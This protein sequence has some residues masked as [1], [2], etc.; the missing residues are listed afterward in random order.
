MSLRQ[1]PIQLSFQHVKRNGRKFRARNDGV[2]LLSP[3]LRRQR[4][5]G[6]SLNSRS[7]WSTEKVP[8]QSRSGGEGN[9]Q[10]KMLLTMYLNEGAMFQPKPQI[11][12]ASVTRVWL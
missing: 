8:E 3:A 10:N 9:H 5:A 1:E 6:G 2:L 12:A 7:E 4:L 11:L